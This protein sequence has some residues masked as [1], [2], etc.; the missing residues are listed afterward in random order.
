MSQPAIPAVFLT[1]RPEPVTPTLPPVSADWK[2]QRSGDCCSLPTE[3]V[4]T[5][6]EAAV[7][8]HHAPREITLRFRPTEDERFV[9]LQ[10][11]PCPL[12]VFK[13]CVVYAHRPYNC[14]RFA[15]MRPAPAVEPWRWTENGDCANL[16]ERIAISRVARRL[17]TLIQRKA[18]KWAVAHGWPMS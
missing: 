18:Q 17:G 3:V 1:K 12:F 7:L 10:A 5:K 11:K 16:R 2:C 4:M 13:T 9:A 8:V 14:R 6:E 15:C